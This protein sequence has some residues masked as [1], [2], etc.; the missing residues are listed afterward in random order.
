MSAHPLKIPSGVHDKN[1]RRRSSGP[2]QPVPRDLRRAGRRALGRFSLRPFPARRERGQRFLQRPRARC[3]ALGHR[4]PH[5]V[6]PL[7]TGRESAGIFGG[8][9]MALPG[10]RLF[11]KREHGPRRSFHFRCRRHHHI[12]VEFHG[13]MKQ[14]AESGEVQA[15][16]RGDADGADVSVALSSAKK[17][18]RDRAVPC[19]E[20]RS[21][22]HAV[23]TRR[24]RP[25]AC[26]RRN[27]D[28]S[29][30]PKPAGSALR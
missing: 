29:T 24:D 18:S 10:Q 22:P 15:V 23:G 16:A 30:S 17:I 27:K 2:R 1:V 25:P 13:G 4:Q 28:C 9:A 3:G 19:R 14:R 20:R 11:E 7:A 5:E 21:S 26:A 12:G 6:F 8:G